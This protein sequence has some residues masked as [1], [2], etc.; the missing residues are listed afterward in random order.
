MRHSNRVIGRSVQN[1]SL[2]LS[3]PIEV[4]TQVIG[5]FFNFESQFHSRRIF[6]PPGNCTKKYQLI[7]HKITKHKLRLFEFSIQQQVTAKTS[8]HCFTQTLKQTAF[9]ILWKTKQPSVFWPCFLLGAWIC[10][11]KRSRILTKWKKSLQFFALRK[12]IWGE[13]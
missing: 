8:F 4:I 5:L 9:R 10:Y 7:G 2:S 12:R 6:D 13:K 11:K 1:N 3:D